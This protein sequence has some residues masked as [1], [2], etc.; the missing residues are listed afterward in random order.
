VFWLAA[1][2]NKKPTAI[3][4]R[5]FLSKFYLGATSSPG[6]A[7]YYYDHSNYL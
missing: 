6:V 2:A 5:G 3:A 7:D 1:R 4:S